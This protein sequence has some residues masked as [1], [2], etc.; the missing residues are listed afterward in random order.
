MHIHECVVHSGHT[1]MQVSECS[2]HV[3]IVCVGVS[4]HI[5]MW[6]LSDPV[7]GTLLVSGGTLANDT[8]LPRE[9]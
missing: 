5:R 9:W 4:A 7:Y 1:D 8:H 3:C 2:W 6:G